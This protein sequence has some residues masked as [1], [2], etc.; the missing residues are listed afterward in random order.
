VNH[1]AHD[2][3][4]GSVNLTG[5][6]LMDR[7]VV[8]EKIARGGMGVLFRGEDERLQRQVCVKVFQT[9]DPSRPE[10][11]T[12]L[13]HFVQEAF[14]L[15]RLQHPNTLRIY[16]FGW[17][18]EVERRNPYF[19]TEYADAGNLATLVEGAGPLPPRDVLRI[20]EPIVG[21][22]REAHDA[23]V[24]HRDIKPSNILFTYAGG[25][26]VPKLADFSIAKALKDMPNRAQDTNAE[27]PLYSLSWAAPE[28]IG[29]GPVGAQA[30]V[31]ALG[32]MTAFMLTGQLVY[33]GVDIIGLYSMRSEGAE[34]RSKAITA[35]GLP[36]RVDAV[37]QAAC[38]EA[39]HERHP[40]VEAFF[41]A[42]EDALD[43]D[44]HKPSAAPEPAA[45]PFPITWGD[46]LAMGDDDD[47]ELMQTRRHPAYDFSKA[48]MP[49][50]PPAAPRTDPVLAAHPGA[51]ASPQGSSA[52]AP[53]HPA[54]GMTP[55]HK[56]H[57][58]IA[59][60]AAPV[61]V[62]GNRRVRLVESSDTPLAVGEPIAG[63]PARVRVTPNEVGGARVH[64]KG[65]NCFIRPAGGRPSS[66]HDVFRTTTIDLLAPTM[67]VRAQVHVLIGNV[68]DGAHVFE[69]GEAILAVPT[70]LASWV[71]V[72]ELGSGR[73]ALLLFRS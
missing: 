44:A 60:L 52:V 24:V 56:P 14:T 4:K 40:S 48:A 67:A 7:Y 53:A 37:I 23:G 6:R 39:V 55:A 36:P 38:A 69:L 43:E 66:G 50:E 68:V 27:V 9:L 58:S 46:D 31:F 1:A 57:L 42:L 12:I 2:S 19:V 59:S 3:A 73:D 65:L 72:L 29:D 22:L 26:P 20:L 71:V 30:D 47:D 17:L 13:E 49:P 25:G 35:F 32:L 34:F 33:P 64:I 16:D 45:A 51:H 18:D 28:Q 8:R 70:A 41:E 11:A 10:Y 5:Q 21:A 62:V 63:V 61:V 15:S 54:V